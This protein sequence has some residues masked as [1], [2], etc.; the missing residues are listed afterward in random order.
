MLKMKVKVI[1]A[2][3]VYFVY[4]FGASSVFADEFEREKLAMIVGTPTKVK[5]AGDVLVE[6]ES[7]EESMF[8]GAWYEVNFREFDV[9][10]GEVESKKLSIL[11]TAGHEAY[12]T[13]KGKIFVLLDVSDQENPKGL[14]WDLAYDVVCFSSGHIEMLDERY[15]DLKVA[16]NLEDFTS[17]NNKRCKIFWKN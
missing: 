15:E 4:F 17:F 13:N 5:F 7:G 1:L 12:F 10:F 6:N 16:E 3:L 8:L 11:L 9:L 2:T 14:W